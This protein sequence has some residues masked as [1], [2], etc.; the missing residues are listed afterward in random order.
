MKFKLEICVDNVES[1]INAQIAGAD[2]VELCDNL[3]EGGTTPGYGT[4]VSAKNNLDISLSVLI[5]P[6]CGDFLYTDLEY[7]IMRR[8]I[9]VCGESGVDGVVLGI[10]LSDGAIDVERTEKLVELAYPMHVTFHRAFDLCHDPLRGIYDVLATGAS[11]LLTS[12]QQDSAETG[13]E[14]ISQLVTRVG[15]KIIIMPGGGINVSNISSIA[16]MTG[17]SE[18]HLSARKTAESD[19]IFRREGISMGSINGISEYSRKVTDPEIV[20]SI[21]KILNEI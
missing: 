15:K 9:D 8:D 13:A 4:I 7:D 21:I 19:M 18:F 20:R 2:R 16:K 12:G 14:L 1:A 17:A 6:R 10:L 11:R 3:I 5:R